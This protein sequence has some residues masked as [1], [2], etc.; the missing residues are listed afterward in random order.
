M[1]NGGPEMFSTN[2]IVSRAAIDDT[3]SA[4]NLSDTSLEIELL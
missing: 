3:G 4:S 2:T 1:N